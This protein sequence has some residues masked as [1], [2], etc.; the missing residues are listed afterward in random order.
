MAKQAHQHDAQW[1]PNRTCRAVGHDWKH[2]LSGV[3]ATYR[4]CQRQGCH[5]A[6]RCVGRAWVQ[7]VAPNARLVRRSHPSQS[8]SSASASTLF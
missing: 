3:H 1:C 4:V 8:S 5:A 6:E 7:V 2:D